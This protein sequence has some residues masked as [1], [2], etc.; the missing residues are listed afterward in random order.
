MNVLAV[1]RRHVDLAD[2]AACDAQRAE[3]HEVLAAVTELV[4]AVEGFRAIIAGDDIGRYK[5]LA[6]ALSR[7]QGVQS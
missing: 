4:E 5:R 2:L 3:A 1:L 6:A 7:V